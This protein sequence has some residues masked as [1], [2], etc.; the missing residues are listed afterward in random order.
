M[1]LDFIEAAILLIYNTRR[2]WDFKKLGPEPPFNNYLTDA[3]NFDLNVG[4]QI[5]TV[6][7]KSQSSRFSFKIFT[8]NS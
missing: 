4:F 2:Y 7:E 1:G 8:L 3:E 6:D 5:Y